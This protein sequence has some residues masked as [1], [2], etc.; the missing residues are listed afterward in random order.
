ML[1]TTGAVSA[2]VGDILCHNHLYQQHNDERNGMRHF[3][4][5]THPNMGRPLCT[6]TS[7]HDHQSQTR[8]RQRANA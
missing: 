8:G 3:K 7:S 1:D 2:S 5:E 4:S 6:P